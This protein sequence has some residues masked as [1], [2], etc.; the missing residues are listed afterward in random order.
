MKPS[1]IL[2]L[3]TSI[4]LREMGGYPTEDGHFIAWHKL[5]RSGSLGHLAPE[6]GLELVHYGLQFDVDLRSNSEVSASP[7]KL[8]RAVRYQHLSVYPFS[9][10]RGLFDKVGRRIRRLAR[11][12]QSGMLET[13]LQMITDSHANQVFG[14][15]F[16][17]LLAH[18]APNDAVLFH[19]TA[20]KD[21]TGVAAMM[22]EGVLGVPEAKIREDYLLTNLVL[23]DPQRMANQE[24]RHGA[25]QFVNEMNAHG[26][27]V[28]NYDAVA[29]IVTSEYGDWTHY[30]QEAL[31]LSTGDIADLKAIYLTDSAEP[32]QNQEATADDNSK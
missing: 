19:C 24:L 27:E 12:S 25:N 29:A 31:G 5:L 2:P 9:D 7:D 8:P 28:E 30:V 23:E 22:I 15:L 1:R 18:D 17:I 16:E 20:G 6:D 14:T 32:P 11:G 10:K 13:Y 26:A 3:A 21:R 4:N